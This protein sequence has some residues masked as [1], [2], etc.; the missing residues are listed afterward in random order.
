M[1]IGEPID[2]E[3]VVRFKIKSLIDRNSL[4]RDFNN[5]LKECLIYI[6]DDDGLYGLVEDNYE[7]L[8]VKEINNG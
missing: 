5:D 8:S 2:V 6:M 4:D 1:M 3:V 7:L